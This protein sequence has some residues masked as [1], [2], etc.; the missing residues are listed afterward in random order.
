MVP[1]QR[2]VTFF[3]HNATKTMDRQ[4]KGDGTKTL[5]IICRDIHHMH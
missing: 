5:A 3:K 2:E 4:G 1:W